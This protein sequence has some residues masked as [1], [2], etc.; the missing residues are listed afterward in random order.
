M[1]VDI[2]KEYT[3]RFLVELLIRMKGSLSLSSIEGD[4]KK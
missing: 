4:D 1:K 2:K 3:T